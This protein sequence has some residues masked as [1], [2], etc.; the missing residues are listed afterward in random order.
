MNSGLLPLST[1]V[2]QPEKPDPLSGEFVNYCL[3]SVTQRVIFAGMRT[4]RL[5]FSFFILFVATAERASGATLGPIS[6][7]APIPSMPTDWTSNSE[8]PQFNPSLGTL[9]MVSLLTFGDF[10]S[11]IT[12]TNTD[13]SGT[14]NG[15]TTVQML[16]SVQDGFK[17]ESTTNCRDRSAIIELHAECWTKYLRYQDGSK[18]EQKKLHSARDPLGVHRNREF[19]ADGVHNYATLNCQSWK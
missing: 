2:F 10:S 18:F 3:P 8:F 5:L 12:V 16:F 9:T 13:A 11:F 17:S 15:N 7:L 1:A 6:A 19:D 14:A 4:I